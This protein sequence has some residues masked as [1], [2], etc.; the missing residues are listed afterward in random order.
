MKLL[1]DIIYY[2]YIE[3]IPD[4]PKLKINGSKVFY[5]IVNIENM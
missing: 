4:N 3:N 1:N 5:Q 2:R